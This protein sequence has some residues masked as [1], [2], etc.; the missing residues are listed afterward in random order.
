MS[1][2]VKIRRTKRLPRQLPRRTI[3]TLLLVTLLCLMTPVVIGVLSFGMGWLSWHIEADPTRIHN[4]CDRQAALMNRFVPG[5][6]ADHYTRCVEDHM[7]R[8]VPAGPPRATAPAVA[9]A[10]PTRQ[11]KKT[12][13]LGFVIQLVKGF[14]EGLF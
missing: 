14:F 5:S 2:Y 12:G 8:A 4:F 6:F 1:P 9:V 7:A 10:A 3:R 13:P 11:K